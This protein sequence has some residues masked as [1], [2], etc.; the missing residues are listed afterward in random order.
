[1]PG[2]ENNYASGSIWVL[3]DASPLV[4]LAVHGDLIVR[5]EAEAVA[6][7]EAVNLIGSL[8]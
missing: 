6:Y 8:R 1:M 3:Q 5:V 4:L 7:N 2:I